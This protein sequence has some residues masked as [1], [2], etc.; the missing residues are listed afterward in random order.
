MIEKHHGK[1]N[2]R[3][4]PYG[5]LSMSLIKKIRKKFPLFK[6]DVD[7]KFVENTD[8]TVDMEYGITKVNMDDLCKEDFRN[9]LGWIHEE[10]IKDII[11]KIADKYLEKNFQAI[12]DGISLQSVSNIASIKIAD[13]VNKS[14]L[15]DQEQC[16]KLE[17]IGCKSESEK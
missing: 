6:G 17:K 10:I 4:K 3:N 11:S 15:E 9:T 2:E 5:G 16:E 12:V 8:D 14:L 1:I 7:V 13:R